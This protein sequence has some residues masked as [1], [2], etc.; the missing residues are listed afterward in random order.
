MSDGKNKAKL[1]WYE[2]P[3]AASIIKIFENF[4]KMVS[5]LKS[6]CQSIS[7]WLHIHFNPTQNVFLILLLMSSAIVINKRLITVLIKTRNE[8]RRSPTSQRKFHVNTQWPTAIQ[9]TFTT[10]HNDP[11]KS[12]TANYDPQQPTASQKNPVTTHNSMGV[13]NPGSL[14]SPLHRFISK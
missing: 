3:C 6:F 5:F 7:K 11:K 14:N 8:P 2:L 9:K 10:I 4:E 1:N 12:T 13:L